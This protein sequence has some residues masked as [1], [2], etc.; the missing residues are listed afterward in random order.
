MPKK[1]V[2]AALQEIFSQVACQTSALEVDIIDLSMFSP[3]WSASSCWETCIFS[4]VCS[5]CVTSKEPSIQHVQRYQSGRRQGGQILT[6]EICMEVDEFKNRALGQLR[7]TFEKLSVQSRVIFIVTK[8]LCLCSAVFK[9]FATFI[10]RFF[11][12]SIETWKCFSQWEYN[13]EQ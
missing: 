4:Y 6:V 9:H 3:V 10:F 13:E 7:S 5:S 1:L 8:L 12:L 2:Q 11:D